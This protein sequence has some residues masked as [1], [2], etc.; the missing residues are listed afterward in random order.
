MANQNTVGPSEIRD[1]THPINKVNSAF[2]IRVLAKVLSKQMHHLDNEP[3]I[4]L[5]VILC[6]F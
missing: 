5:N 3:P 4:H 6:E 1:K 2:A